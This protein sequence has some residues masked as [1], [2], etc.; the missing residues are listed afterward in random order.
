MALGPPLVSRRD[1][2]GEG[3][4]RLPSA[5]ASAPGRLLGVSKR[6]S[7][8]AQSVAQRTGDAKMLP[9]ELTTLA[10]HMA[11]A[12]PPLVQSAPSEG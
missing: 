7:S 10:T 1:R 3:D 2:L 12:P 11:V 9:N 8:A 6:K 5:A 4:I